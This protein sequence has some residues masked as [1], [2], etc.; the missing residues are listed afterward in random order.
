M[1]YE[2]I[3]QN[4]FYY[5]K[6]VV[7]SFNTLRLKPRAD[8]CQRL[9]SYQNDVHPLPLRKEHVDV[10]G[11]NIETIFIAEPHSELAIKSTSLVSV[12]RSPFI[13]GLTYSTEMKDIFQSDTFAKQYVMFLGNTAYTTLN[14]SQIQE[15]LREI[16]PVDDPISFSLRTMAYLHETI[17]YTPGS[18]NVQTTAA[19]AFAMRQG[20]CQD[21]TH[22]MLSILRSQ[23]IPSRYVSGYL[24]VEENSS[25]VG[26]VASHAWVEVMVPGIGWVGLDPTNNVE[27]LMNHVRIGSA[28]DYS[29]V[30]PVEGVYQGGNQ[31]LEVHVQ[32][33]ALD[34]TERG[35]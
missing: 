6:P 5:E 17:V 4:L 23:S 2:I 12:Q 10:W 35:Q 34:S 30:S 7:Q 18:T 32:V 8:E 16:G 33:I 20:V 29:D 22:V 27:V 31:T 19:E 13:Q 11:N 24:Y 14:V 1:E 21:I 25:F 28:R 26:D 9:M 3:H 15:A